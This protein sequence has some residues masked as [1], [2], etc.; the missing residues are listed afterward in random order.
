[1]VTYRPLIPSWVGQAVCSIVCLMPYQHEV[2]TLEQSSCYS[3]VSHRSSIFPLYINVLPKQTKRN[4]N[5]HICGFYTNFTIKWDFFHCN[6]TV[7]KPN[8]LKI[9]VFHKM[10]LKSCSFHLVFLDCSWW[11][12]WSPGRPFFAFI[13]LVI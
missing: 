8:T 9:L 6:F 11:S 5:V 4:F 13:H 2:C 7:W 3:P 1:M 12:M 10:S